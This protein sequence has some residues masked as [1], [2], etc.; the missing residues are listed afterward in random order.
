MDKAKLVELVHAFVDLC[1]PQ[2]RVL[3]TLADGE[4]EDYLDEN[5]DL[6]TT[7]L[8]SHDTLAMWSQLPDCQYYGMFLGWFMAK[9]YDIQ[10]ISV[11]DLEL[12]VMQAL[13]GTSSTMFIGDYDAPKVLN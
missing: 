8:S 2:C 5:G 13:T 7:F 4:L 3:I 1:A 11:V 6:R 9:G 10:E 12:A